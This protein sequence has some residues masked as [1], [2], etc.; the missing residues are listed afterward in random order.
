M[1]TPETTSA[2]PTT[3]ETTSASPTTPGTTSASPTTPETTSAL[4]T[5][6]ETTSGS[7]TT[8]E[9]TS[10]PP[11][12]PEITTIP[13]TT[14]VPLKDC[15]SVGPLT[16]QTEEDSLEAEKCSNITGDLVISCDRSK[17][18]CFEDFELTGLSNIQV[19]KVS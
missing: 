2:S 3:P 4:P 11:T 14:P 16:T 15:G 18:D 13:P 12:V 1:T 10:A 19:Q 17:E 7:P 8:P 5:T 6:P 9:T